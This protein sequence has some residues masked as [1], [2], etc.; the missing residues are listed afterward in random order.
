MNYSNNLIKANI[1]RSTAEHNL[2]KRD[3][4]VISLLPLSISV[5]FKSRHTNYSQY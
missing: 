4:S 3:L 1:T 5:K 2:F